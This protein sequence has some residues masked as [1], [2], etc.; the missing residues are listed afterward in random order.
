MLIKSS[1]FSLELNLI[2]VH[3]LRV[4]LKSIYFVCNRLFISFGFLNNDEELLVSQLV[5]FALDILIFVSFEQL[6]LTVFVLFVLTFEISELTI[7]FVQIVFFLLNGSMSLIDRH[8]ILGKRFFFMVEK[9]LN[10]FTSLI[11]IVDL[12]IQNVHSFD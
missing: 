7:K 9:T 6:S 1:D 12:N 2:R 11:V 3:L 8:G 10:A 5:L 4:R